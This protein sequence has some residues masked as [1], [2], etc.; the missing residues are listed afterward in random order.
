M[1]VPYIGFLG[2]IYSVVLMVFGVSTYHKV[3]KG[4]AVFPVLLPAIIGFILLVGFIA[5]L[6]YSLS[7]AF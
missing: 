7:R 4:K 3:S 2:S 5:F 6:I 1:I